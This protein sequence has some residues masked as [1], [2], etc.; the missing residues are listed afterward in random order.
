VA[1]AGYDPAY[2]ARPVQR[3]LENLVILPLASCPPGSWQAVLEDGH[4]HW[5]AR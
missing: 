5:V 2:G 4:V 1:T 3:A